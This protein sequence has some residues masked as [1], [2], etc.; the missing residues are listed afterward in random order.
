MPLFRV[1]IMTTNGNVVS[2]VI[3]DFSLFI[4]DFNWHCLPCGTSGPVVRVERLMQADSQS[5][6]DEPV[7][8]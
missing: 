7:S 6:H 8:D 4:N 2:Q 5:R 1:T 3:E